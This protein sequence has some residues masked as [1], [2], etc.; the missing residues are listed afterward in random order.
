MGKVLVSFR[1]CKFVNFNVN[2]KNF[3]E[4]I[5]RFYPLDGRRK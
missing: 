1:C 3:P 4:K 2:G 5:Y